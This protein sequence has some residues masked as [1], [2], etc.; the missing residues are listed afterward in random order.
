[1]VHN[2]LHSPK[3]P[4]GSPHAVRLSPIWSFSPMSIFVLLWVAQCCGRKTILLSPS[5]LHPS[6]RH[7]VRS[8]NF[9]MVFFGGKT[10]SPTRR[11]IWYHL[12]WPQASHTSSVTSYFTGRVET[13]WHA[14]VLPNFIPF[15]LSSPC[16]TLWWQS[17]EGRDR[18][19]LSS[20]PGTVPGPGWALKIDDE[21]I[22]SSILFLIYQVTLLC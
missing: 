13:I 17:G 20:T 15:S 21:R 4:N 1:M 22:E 10:S 11:P 12:F 14:P 16:P 7:P 5:W 19:V 8:G 6:N 9:P 3:L 2:R 18:S